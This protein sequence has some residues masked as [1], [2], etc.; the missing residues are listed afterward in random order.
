[1][2]RPDLDAIRKRCE[3]ATL[4]PWVVDYEEGCPGCPIGVVQHADAGG[5]DIFDALSEGHLYAD[6]Q[7]AAHA[8]QDIPEL[9]DYVL[10]LERLCLGLQQ[11]AAG[12]TRTIEE[13]EAENKELLEAFKGVSERMEF[14]LK[15]EKP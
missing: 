3:D 10:E 1:M 12:E 14:L 2:K 7:F 5:E 4:G 8:R 6:C 13:T 15:N 9:C 11:A